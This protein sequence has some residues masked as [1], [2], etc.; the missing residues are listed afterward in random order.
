MSASRIG[1]AVLGG[2]AAACLASA[3]YVAGQALRDETIRRNWEP[4]MGIVTA[5]ELRSPLLRDPLGGRL[6]RLQ[7]A[8]EHGGR[9]ITTWAERDVTMARPW[10]LSE[11]VMPPRRGDREPVL[12][13]PVAPLRVMP[14]RAMSSVWASGFLA[15]M[16]LCFALGLGGLARLSWTQLGRRP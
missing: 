6:Y 8:V 5:V 11:A 2:F 14:A 15:L 4:A 3:I 13:S 1:A 7:I 16:L 12:V 10:S 9:T